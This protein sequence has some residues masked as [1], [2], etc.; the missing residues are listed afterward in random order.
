MDETVGWDHQLNRH[1]F[2]QEFGETVKD[3]KAWRA[4]VPGGRKGSDTTKQ[5]NNNYCH[6]GKKLICEHVL[7][8]PLFGQ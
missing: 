6:L 8:S 3:S 4:A 2:E 1:E 5:L 7:A